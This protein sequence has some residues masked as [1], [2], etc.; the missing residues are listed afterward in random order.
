MNDI[1]IVIL[2]FHIKRSERR[3]A[4]LLLGLVFA[5]AGCATQLPPSGNDPARGRI[6]VERMRS[7]RDAAVLA[8]GTRVCR[9]MKFGIAESDWIAA[10]VLAP[11]IPGQWRVEIID[12]GRMT[13]SLNGVP[14]RNNTIIEATPEFWIPCR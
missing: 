5:L 14:I 13:H 11:T 3:A 1:A 8:P 10:R 6:I 7:E 12:Q 2:S 4:L 9:E